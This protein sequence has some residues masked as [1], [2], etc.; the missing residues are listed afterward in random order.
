MMLSALNAILRLLDPADAVGTVVAGVLKDNVETID[1]VL[2]PDGAEFLRDLVRILVRILVPPVLQLSD[3]EGEI[4]D[5]LAE[6]SVLVEGDGLLGERLEREEMLDAAVH[7][8]FL[9]VGK[10]ILQQDA[11][12]ADLAQIELRIHDGQEVL[13]VGRILFDDG[14]GR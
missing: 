4:L 14:G 5:G 1:L 10:M 11:L 2:F 13:R 7:A 3:P 9:G 6:L 8:P 12:F